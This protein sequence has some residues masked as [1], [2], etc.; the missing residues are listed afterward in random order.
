VALTPSPRPLPM[1]SPPLL[2]N[3]TCQHPPDHIIQRPEHHLRLLHLPYLLDQSLSKPYQFN[4]PYFLTFLHPLLATPL[5]CA[6]LILS[7]L[8]NT[9]TPL[10]S[11]PSQTEYFKSPQIIHQ[12]L[13]TS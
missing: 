10:S 1:H 12:S 7:S 13:N 6:I 4:F 8:V 9:F 3:K 11:H 5:L 2:C